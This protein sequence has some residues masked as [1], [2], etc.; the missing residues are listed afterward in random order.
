MTTTR[1]LH[2][3]QLIRNPKEIFSLHHLKGLVTLTANCVP[4]P[5]ILAVLTT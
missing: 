4:D 3:S 1:T 2:S 5:M